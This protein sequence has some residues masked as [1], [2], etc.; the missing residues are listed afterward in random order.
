MFGEVDTQNIETIKKV[1][2]DYSGLSGQ[3]VN[4]QKSSIYF[5]KQVSS[6]LWDSIIS[7]LEIN[8]TGDQGHILGYPLL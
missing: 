2:Q 5:D 3:E 6:T 8:N 4:Y 1:L 7:V